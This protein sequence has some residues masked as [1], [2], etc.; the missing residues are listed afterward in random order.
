MT[1]ERLALARAVQH[2]LDTGAIS[3]RWPAGEIAQEMELALASL[4]HAVVSTAPATA[5]PKPTSRYTCT[6]AT[7]PW[8]IEHPFGP[9]P[10]VDTSQS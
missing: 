9:P 6:C 4:E 7:K 8:C 10:E 5:E 3:S 2:V 1:G